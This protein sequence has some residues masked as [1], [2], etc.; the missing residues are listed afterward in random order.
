MNNNNS[1]DSDLFYPETLS[2]EQQW[3]V[4]QWCAQIRQRLNEQLTTGLTKFEAFEGMNLGGW[5]LPIPDWATLD[6]QVGGY[7]ELALTFAGK[8][9]ETPVGFA[10]LDALVLVD[11]SE[12][13]DSPRA[14]ISQP[15]VNV[16]IS[17]E[18]MTPSQAVMLSE[19]IRGAASE[20]AS[21]DLTR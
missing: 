5:P 13:A 2:V 8:V 3:Q 14:S 16:K 7:M 10:L 12:F 9:H 11:V 18:N 1:T 17:D 19:A 6:A 21:L 4:E 20:L 15:R